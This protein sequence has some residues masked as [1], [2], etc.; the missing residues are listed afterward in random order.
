MKKKIIMLLVLALSGFA[1]WYI[2][3]TRKKPKDEIPA[4]KVVVPSKYSNTFNQSVTT[5]LN[6]YYSLSEAFVNWDSAGVK[7][8]AAKLSA[9]I[10]NIDLK[11]T[12]IDSVN[13]NNTIAELK[14][15]LTVI[16]SDKDL[17]QKRGIFNDFSKRFYTML[18]NAKYDNAVVYLQKCPMAF[19]DTG[20]GVW[21]SSKDEIRNP[22]LGM[23]HPKYGK[24]MLA[25]G[26]TEDKLDYTG[27]EK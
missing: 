27:S 25:C 1:A 20:A 2:W 15:N 13:R 22:Y 19:N 5:A 10:E 8:G 16:G 14:N 9:D 12:G 3:E 21:L 7:T 18:Q 17:A 6:S 26:E 11:E 4:E 23:H 24:G